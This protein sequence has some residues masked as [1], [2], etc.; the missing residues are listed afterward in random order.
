MIDLQTGDMMLYPDL[1]INGNLTFSD[2]EKTSFYKYQN[3]NR[4]IDLAEPQIIDNRKY[5]V[6]LIFHNGEI[7]SVYLLND[8]Y[9]FTPETEPER[10]KVHDD[11]LSSYNITPGEEHSW[12]EI[13]SSYDPRSNIS[14]INIFYHF[15][16]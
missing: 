9:Q 13:E 5:Y 3:P 4:I 16:N 7:Y 2:F 14:S 6:S 11:I 10:K 15:E 8:D 1:E 12:G